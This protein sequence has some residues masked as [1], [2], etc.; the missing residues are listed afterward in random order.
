MTFVD[1]SAQDENKTLQSE[2]K[3]FKTKTDT[4]VETLHASALYVCFKATMT[5][6]SSIIL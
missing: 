5:M 3:T 6:T 1:I 2:T 4:S